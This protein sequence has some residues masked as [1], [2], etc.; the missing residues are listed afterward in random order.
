M[1]LNSKNNYLILGLVCLL[2]A[3]CKL[4]TPLQGKQ[5]A[6]LPA[7]Y[8]EA[9]DTVNSGTIGWRAF[10][11][12][13]YLQALIDTALENNLEMKS[14]LQNI[15]MARNN[16]LWRQGLLRPNVKAGGALGIEKVGL[17]TSQGAGDASADITPGK[18]V[19]EWLPDLF[20]AFQASWEA[21]IWGKLRTAKKA[22]YAKLLGSVEGRNFVQTNLIAEL[23][24]SYYELL[25][26]DNQLVLIRKSIALQKDVLEIVKVQKEATVANEL[27]VKQ[28]EAHLYSSQGLEFEAQQRIKEVENNINFLLGRFPQKIERD[29]SGLLQQSPSVIREGIPAQLLSNR[30]DIRQAELELTSAKLDVRVA[31]LEF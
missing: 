25:A 9:K 6:E 29:Q 31:Q 27:A 26:L 2:Y 24:N 5:G 30:P 7:S 4:P 13:R 1:R 10:I 12:D 18:K 16:V 28:F 20:L 15:E 23:A 8:A 21:D 14:T 22:A 19:P 3:S 17:Y 11:T